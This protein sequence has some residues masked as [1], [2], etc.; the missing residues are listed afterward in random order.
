VEIFDR[1]EIED[2]QSKIKNCR[3]RKGDG[4]VTYAR[5]TGA[6]VQ[7]LGSAWKIKLSSVATN[8]VPHAGHLNSQPRE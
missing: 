1:W 3:P 4:W 8:P 7:S 2:Q 6:S 5:Q